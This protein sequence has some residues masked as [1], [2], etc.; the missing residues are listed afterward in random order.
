LTGESLRFED[1]VES[2]DR[3]FQVLA[4][5]PS[6]A[7]PP[8]VAVLFSD[9]TERKRAEQA[10]RDSAERYERQV[11]L[12]DGV[13]STTPDFVYLF[14]LDGRFQYANRRL[15]EVWGMKFRDVLGKTCRELG[16]E[17]WHHDMHMREMAQVIK[18]KRP[19]KGEVP[20]KAPLTGVFGV[21][22][23]IFTPV[24]GPDG[25]VELIAGT[26]RDITERKQMED[27]L[28]QAQEKLQQHA[29]TLERT[30][31]DRTAQLR[32]TI[33]DL[34]QFSYSLAHDL[35]A[36]LR[37]MCSF[38]SF[39]L[40][41]Y[42]PRLDATGL[43]YLNRV[44]S[45]AKRMDELIRD[46]LTY[47]QVVRTQ[48]PV[49]PVDLDVLVR[50]IVSQYPHLGPDQAQ[51]EVVSPLRPVI[52]NRALLTQCVSNLLG[53]AVKFVAPDVKPK[54]LVWTEN[55]G[56]HVRLCVADNGIGVPLGQLERIWR[57]FERAHPDQYPGTGI[58]L[59]IV[60]RAVEKMGGSLGVHSVP[61]EG[62]TF[63]FEL[64]QA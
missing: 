26:T 38:S 2:L 37:S 12:F 25:K 36:P 43:D 4:Y 41:D 60:K 9:I 16:Y 51:I 46:V 23:Y 17:Q 32:E 50:Q 1:R 13:A 42:G 6:D 31:Q 61:G 27:A 3:W 15:L 10:L 24:I 39:L 20:F 64:D 52:G 22:E 55:H 33:V 28:R 54:V 7:V 11:R 44:A 57:I 8:Q 19:I 18:T 35:R 29:Q 40:E 21:Y 56:G 34:E 49:E 5:K 59:S 48:T 58:G 14:D 45:A 62:S 47:S 30:V 63:W 53:N